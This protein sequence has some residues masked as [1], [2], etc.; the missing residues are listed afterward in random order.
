MVRWR[1]LNGSQEQESDLRPALG[2]LDELLHG[3]SEVVHVAF[4]AVRE[5]LHH[6]LEVSGVVDMMLMVGLLLLDLVADSRGQS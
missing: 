6:F 1:V 5:V 3:I 2:L 4:Q